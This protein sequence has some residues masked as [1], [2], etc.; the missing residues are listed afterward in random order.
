MPQPYAS[1]RAQNKA[2]QFIKPSRTD[3]RISCSQYP[4]D[5]YEVSL[6]NVDTSETSDAAVGPRRLC[7]V[8]SPRQRR[9]FPQYPFRGAPKWS[10]HRRSQHRHGE[11]GQ[12]HQIL[13]R[14]D[15]RAKIWRQYQPNT[16]TATPAYSSVQQSQPRLGFVA[17]SLGNDR[18]RSASVLV[19][20]QHNV[21]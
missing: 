14:T 16:E 2:L 18:R 19:R 11:N 12:N 7:R 20:T 13:I 6:R 9:N 4:E 3:S 8:L 21:S 15:N 5:G 1:P 17:V 10:V